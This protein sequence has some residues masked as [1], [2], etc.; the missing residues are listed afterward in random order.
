MSK[1]P[2]DSVYFHSSV[3]ETINAFRGEFAALRSEFEQRSSGR[4]YLLNFLVGS[5]QDLLLCCILNLLI[6]PT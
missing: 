6:Q 5:H 2:V 1:E 3:V 4:S